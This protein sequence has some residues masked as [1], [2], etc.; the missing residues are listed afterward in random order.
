MAE[1]GVAQRARQEAR[2]ELAGA[3]AH[4]DHLERNFTTREPN[5]LRLRVLS[6]AGRV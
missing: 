5:R 1:R 3:Q 6:D 2:Q 4:D